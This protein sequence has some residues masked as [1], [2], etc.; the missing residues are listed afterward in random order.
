LEHD[1]YKPLQNFSPRSSLDGM[2]APTPQPSVAHVIQSKK[3]RELLE[4]RKNWVFTSP[5]DLTGASKAEDI[6]NLPEYGADGKENKKT[7]AVENFYERLERERHGK[8][9]DA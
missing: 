5:D 7:A 2:D 4:R 1:L 9:G 8:T 6:F 3:V